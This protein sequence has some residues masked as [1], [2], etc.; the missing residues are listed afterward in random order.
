MCG[1]YMEWHAAATSHNLVAYFL[2]PFCVLIDTISLL[3]VQ[4]IYILYR[5]NGTMTLQDFIIIFGAVQLLLSQLP[6]IHSLRRVNFL[7]TLCTIGFTITCVAMSIKNGVW[8]SSRLYPSKSE[9]H[10]NAD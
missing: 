7:C 3:F 5:P 10:S 8:A 1:L 2:K 4:S 9:P 6:T